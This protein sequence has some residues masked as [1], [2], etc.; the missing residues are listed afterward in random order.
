MLK[1]FANIKTFSV[2]IIFI[3]IFFVLFFF[4]K[5]KKEKEEISPPSIP[6]QEASKTKIEPTKII[7]EKK[8]TVLRAREII[9]TLGLSEGFTIEFSSIPSTKDFFYE[10]SPSTSLNL[11][12]D[13][14]TLLVMPK[15][16]WDPK[17]D[18]VFKIKKGTK[19]AY[20]NGIGEDFVY[21][22]KTSAEGG[23]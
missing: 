5:T 9:G 21:K 20:G 23:I 14:T 6:T 11:S 17:T 7:E 16:K 18:Y 10:I 15:P 2:L 13:G 22:F 3:I 1:K 12:I 4:S 8:F 19:D